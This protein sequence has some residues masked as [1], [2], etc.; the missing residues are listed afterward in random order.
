MP[1]LYLV[2]EK[3]FQVRRLAANCKNTQDFVIKPAHGSGGDGIL[4]IAGRMGANYRTVGGVLMPQEELDHH[5]FSTLSGLY[6][7][8]GQTDQALIE[9]RVDSTLALRTSATRGCRISASSS[10]GGCRS[11]PCCACPPACPG[12]R[13]TCTRG[14]SGS[15]STWPPASP[16]A[17]PGS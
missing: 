3:E 2:V 7:L 6:S 11:W 9:Y 13:P 12:A 10:S 8:G 17:G 4:V 16:W 5:V 15:A 1:E 14:P